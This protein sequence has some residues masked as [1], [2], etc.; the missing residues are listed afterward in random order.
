MVIKS[1]KEYK[2]YEARAEALMQRGTQLGDMDLLSDFAH[3]C[4]SDAGKTER[5]EAEGCGPYDRYQFDNVQRPD[6][7]AA[8]TKLRSGTQHSQDAWHTRRCCISVRHLPLTPSPTKQRTGQSKY[9][10]QL[11]LGSQLHFIFV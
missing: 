10:C 6:S 8:F 9:C 4:H 3:R 1:E 2:D 5:A 11:L 7:R